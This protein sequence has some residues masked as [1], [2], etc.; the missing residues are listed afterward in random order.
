MEVAQPTLIS[1][2]LFRPLVVVDVIDGSWFA[3][4]SDGATR[5]EITE[6]PVW[7]CQFSVDDR[8]VLHVDLYVADD[9]EQFLRGDGRPFAGVC[10]PVS[11]LR[12]HGGIYRT[13]LGLQRGC[14]IDEAQE[15]LGA[16][17]VYERFETSVLLAKNL[18]TPKICCSVMNADLTNGQGAL[19][20]HGQGAERCGVILQQSV[21]HHSNIVTNLHRQLCSLWAKGKL[22]CAGNV[23][24]DFAARLTDARLDDQGSAAYD[25]Q[26]AQNGADLSWE[27]ERQRLQDEVARLTQTA[28]LL[29][30]R[31]EESNHLRL[32]Y[33][34]RLMDL[35]G[36]VLEDESLATEDVPENLRSLQALQR[37][38]RQLNEALQAERACVRSMQKD[39]EASKPAWLQPDEPV[40]N[41]GQCSVEQLRRRHAD[42]LSRLAHIHSA[43]I[44]AMRGAEQ[45]QRALAQELQRKN[46]SLGREAMR[47]QTEVIVLQQEIRER[48]AHM[49][50]AWSTQSRAAQS[51]GQATLTNALGMA[52]L[53]AARREA[54]QLRQRLQ[55]SEQEA[56]A[57]Y[58]SAAT[59]SRPRNI[60][61]ERARN[62]LLDLRKD[63]AARLSENE[64][65]L[66]REVENLMSLTERLQ[67][68]RDG[69]RAASDEHCRRCEV[70]EK[71]AQQLQ[72]E[73]DRAAGEAMLNASSAIEQPQLQDLASMR[74]EIVSSAS[75][76]SSGAGQQRGRTKA[77]ARPHQPQAAA[78]ADEEQNVKFQAAQKLLGTELLAAREAEAIAKD[79]L[80]IVEEKLKRSEAA[81]KLNVRSDA[82]KAVRAEL[83]NLKA[84]MKSRST[85][86]AEEIKNL[87]RD[88]EVEKFH[89]S[90]QAQTHEEALRRRDL[91]QR[92]QLDNLCQELRSELQAAGPFDEA[93]K[94]EFEEYREAQVALRSELQDLE[95][96]NLHMSEHM[97]EQNHK[98]LED[99]NLMQEHIQKEVLNLRK[100]KGISSKSA[101]VNAEL[102]H[103]RQVNKTLK[104]Q[105]LEQSTSRVNASGVR[106]AVRMLSSSSATTDDHE[107]SSLGSNT[108]SRYVRPI[109]GVWGV[110]GMQDISRESPALTSDR[111]RASKDTTDSSIYYGTP[112]VPRAVAGSAALNHHRV[113][114][115]SSAGAQPKV[116]AEDAS[117]EWLRSQFRTASQQVVQAVPLTA[118]LPQLDDISGSASANVRIVMESRTM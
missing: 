61:T 78:R 25:S 70:A 37:E 114:P 90:E 110:E 103:L 9:A 60:I 87:K 48:T 23:N 56:D 5:V 100:D 95:D 52:E 31:L 107:R 57:G 38:N 85:E 21:V 26:A 3:V 35:T 28:I 17:A 18:L 51:D 104:Q 76:T 108:P 15:V 49:V 45:Q 34:E 113:V 92:G 98:Q 6:W 11:Q 40:E 53:E 94:A 115:V 83:E 81:S 93:I 79:K 32:G 116:I 24:G 106:Q 101:V 33:R 54:E 59:S 12:K 99:F 69:S 47:K 111:S 118:E 41:G 105:L 89:L 46:E 71:R 29:T 73:V 22:V 97:S 72:R 88:L 1:V 30:S 75:A 16:E 43:E 77:A 96:V 44:E 8:T 20:E 19:Q 2:N 4:V 117:V 74:P 84:T 58:S 65:S 82:D 50:E 112:T 7:D 13:W 39:L 66:S 86:H 14:H 42:E 27:E 80:E 55:A 102:I 91:Q 63:P 10:I 62:L 67:R 68:E 64:R 36:E 109:E